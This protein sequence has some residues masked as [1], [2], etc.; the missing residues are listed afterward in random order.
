MQAP[1]AQ[2]GI[3]RAEASDKRETSL[4]WGGQGRRKE[5]NQERSA[6]DG[7]PFTAHESSTI[8]RIIT[9]VIMNV[10][11]ALRMLDCKTFI[12]LRKECMEEL[13][14]SLRAT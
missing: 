5:K 10:L 3:S 13:T 7:Y 11:L 14:A 6:S 4:F 1:E 2:N 12:F 8:I 9:T